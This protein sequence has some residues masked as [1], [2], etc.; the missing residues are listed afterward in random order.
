MIPSLLG[1]VGGFP[2][3]ATPTPALA[4][5]ARGGSSPFPRT[6]PATAAVGGTVRFASPA[7][8]LVDGGCGGNG[9]GG[10]GCI[11]LQCQIG[12][13]WGI[14]LLHLLFFLH[15]AAVFDDARRDQL[16]K[17]AFV[18]FLILVG[19]RVELYQPPW[20]RGGS[21]RQELSESTL[22]GDAVAID[23][24]NPNMAA[25]GGPGEKK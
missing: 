3:A 6:G 16:A 22:G 17:G 18:H 14:Q 19:L 11:L 4:R 5:C 20:I 23:L 21:L 2:I 9:C 10:G 1:A 25:P 24:R 15:V 8:G 12:P 13:R 7:R